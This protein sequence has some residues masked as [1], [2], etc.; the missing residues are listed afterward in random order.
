MAQYHFHLNDGHSD[1]DHALELRDDA[2]AIA[3]GLKT[4]SGLM[5]D[6][7]LSD[8]GS[9]SHTLKVSANGETILKIEIQMIRSR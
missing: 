2:S 5:S 8:V 4:A 3:E 9:R 1:E 7:N 6:V